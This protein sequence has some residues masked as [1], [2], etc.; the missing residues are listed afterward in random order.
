MGDGKSLLCVTLF[1]ALSVFFPLCRKGFFRGVLQV[2]VCD[3]L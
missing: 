2:G 3:V 1:I